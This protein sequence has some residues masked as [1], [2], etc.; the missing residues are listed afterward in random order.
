MIIE[1]L[2]SIVCSYTATVKCNIPDDIFTDEKFNGTCTVDYKG[3]RYNQE[4]C[5]M[6]KVRVKPRT[7]NVD[8]CNVTQLTAK[9]WQGLGCKAD[10]TIIC[11]KENVSIYLQC[12]QLN[13]NFI[14]EINGKC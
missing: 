14:K 3:E 1:L 9:D 11:S 7:P 2:F 8:T 4:S 10:F 12:L 6:T 13:N 5:E